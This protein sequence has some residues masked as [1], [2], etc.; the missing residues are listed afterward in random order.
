M[1]DYSPEPP[2]RN[3][4]VHHTFENVEGDTVIDQSPQR[5][6]GTLVGNVTLGHP[7]TVGTAA[8]LVDDDADVEV[9]GV[10]SEFPLDEFAIGGWSRSDD[11]VPAGDTNLVASLTVAGTNYTLSHTVSEAVDEWQFGYLSYDGTTARLW[12]ARRDESMRLVDE[13]RIGGEAS[14]AAIQFETRRFGYVDDVRLYRTGLDES[15]LRGLFEIGAEHNSLLR[16]KQSWGS[17]A[18]PFRGANRRFAGTL[19]ERDDTIFR[20]LDAIREARH[21]GDAAGVQLDRIGKLVGVRREEDE[22]D[23]RYRARISGTAIAGRSSGTFND[24]LRATATIVETSESRVELQTEFSTDPATAFV[25]VRTADLQDSALTTSDLKSILEDAVLAGHRVEVIEQGANP[26]T[27]IN[28][29]QTND[30]D[31]GL[32]SDG[33][34]TGGGL[35]SDA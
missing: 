26:F 28:D 27:V 4:L 35:V 29:T 18:I 6:D 7:G 11:P 12:Y 14:D 33:I 22:R 34:S 32:T 30:P 5:N 24:L 23:A 8:R 25:Y 20:H 16:L 15:Q 3:L 10:A 17:D 31:K 9:A 1:G 13:T 19:A 21:I 2:R